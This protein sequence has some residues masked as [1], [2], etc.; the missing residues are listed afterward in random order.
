MVHWHADVLRLAWSEHL[1]GHKITWGTTALLLYVQFYVQLDQT[2]GTSA[3]L[4]ILFLLYG[5]AY[6]LVQSELLT[7]KDDINGKPR[8]KQERRFKLLHVDEGLLPF[9]SGFQVVNQH[10]WTL[11]DRVWW[12]GHCLL[13]MRGGS[14]LGLIP[15]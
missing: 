8:A 13:F 9:T 12:L 7:E 15:L 3:F 11:S 10:S 1:C 4:C 6:F 2:T 5:I 14:S